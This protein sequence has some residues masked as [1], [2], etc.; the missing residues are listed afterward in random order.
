[1]ATLAL[2]L[3]ASFAGAS[4]SG[5]VEPATFEVPFLDAWLEAPQELQLAGRERLVAELPAPVRILDRSHRRVSIG[6]DG[7]L[8][9]SPSERALP[10][11]LAWEPDPIAA[12]TLRLDV[13]PTRLVAGPESRLLLDWSPRLQATVVRWHAFTRQDNG[14]AVTVEAWLGADGALRV[15][16]WTTGGNAETLRPRFSLGSR[17]LVELP[18]PKSSTAAEF[19]PRRPLLDRPRPAGVDDCDNCSPEFSWSLPIEIGTHQNPTNRNDTASCAPWWDGTLS[20]V[21][22]CNPN[23]DTD[24]CLVDGLPEL[25]GF[26]RT[27]PSTRVDT[28]WELDEDGR[29][30]ECNYVFYVLSECGREMHLPFMGMEGAQVSV[31]EVLTG[32]QV[33]VRCQNEASRNPP[34][35]FGTGC[36]EGM[37]A[38]TYVF[39][40]FDTTD[41]TVS[42]GLEDGCIG[43]GDLDTDGDGFVRCDELGETN[44]NGQVVIPVSPGDGQTMDCYIEAADSLCGIY[45][46]EI[47]SGGWYWQLAANCDGQPIEQFPIYDRCSDACLAWEPAPELHIGLPT[48][49]SCPDVEVCFRY[50]NLGCGDAAATQVQVTRS[51]APAEVFDLAA[52][53]A[54]ESRTECVMIT[55]PMPS[56]DVN[57]TIDPFD[58]VAE[59][60]ETTGLSACSIPT[61]RKVLGLTICDCAVSTFVSLDAPVQVCETAALVVDA[62]ASVVDPCAAPDQIEYSFED[63]T[64]GGSSGWVTSS[65]WDFGTLSLG[66]HDIDVSARCSSDLS[67]VGRSGIVVDVVPPPAVVIAAEPAGDACIGQPVTLDAGFHG[68]G[69]QYL[70]SQ[71]PP[72]PA[73]GA[74]TREVVVEPDLDTVYSVRVTVGGCVEQ[75]DFELL[76]DAADSD[77]DGLGDG[78]DNCPTDANPGQEDLDGD[79]SGDAC[80]NCPVLSNPDQANSDLDSFGNVCDNCPAQSN[81]DQADSEDGGAGDGVGDACDNCPTLLNPAQLDDDGDG[82]GNPCDLDACNL[83]AADIELR[84]RVEVDALWIDWTER[85]GAAFS[86]FNV[87][88]GPLGSLGAGYGHAPA[89]NGC[90]LLTAT[91]EDPAFVVTGTDH[92]YLVVAACTVA[93]QDDLESSYGQSSAPLTAERPTSFQLS[94]L[95][96]P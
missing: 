68:P 54:G 1:M 72:G 11:E 84:V 92:Y 78:C 19:V 59:C 71:I 48:A 21:G 86:H 43:R 8:E 44:P 87:H 27:T 94:G 45:R 88:E 10:A 32:E 20:S 89:I 52:L 2:T 74:T 33:P 6:R 39:P 53:A 93:G 56:V 24:E 81:E 69:T 31:T 65:T 28:L 85:S 22:G 17:V 37:G 73:D 4:S 29:C 18:A 57:L 15:Q 49:T 42:W 95:S 26:L 62:S 76:V 13:F 75:V 91:Y 77:A 7:W 34:A 61:A 9:L 63:L 23:V 12:P 41:S 36:D 79:E 67:C 25:H 96:C 80:D 90:G 16:H 14:R 64:G 60:S 46:V 40:E 30:G 38:T 66:E 5:L 51:T 3:P 58:T 83:A 50:E 35:E 47:V 55:E 70:W 82:Q